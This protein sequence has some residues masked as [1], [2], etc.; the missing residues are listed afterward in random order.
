MTDSAAGVGSRSAR[1][2][3]IVLWAATLGLA[4]WIGSQL[5][6]AAPPA[7]ADA[8][9]G[10]APLASRSATPPAPDAPGSAEIRAIIRDELARQLAE[11]RAPPA[12]AEIAA[13][14]PEPGPL[15]AEL[16]AHADDASGLVDRAI[17][18]GRWTG[19]DRRR[20]ASATGELPP[21]VLIEL[22]RKLHVAINRG[23]VAVVDGFAPFGPPAQAP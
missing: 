21:P 10:R 19:D 22:E 20:F 5:G 11:L 7:A 23:A 18:A 9:R 2:R 15:S 3:W 1:L 12:A 8:P 17:G 6:R 14:A 16:T 4:A 13:H